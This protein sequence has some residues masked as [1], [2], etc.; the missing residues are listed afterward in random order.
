MDLADGEHACLGADGVQL[1]AG[2]VGAQ[3]G[4]QLVADVAL[5]PGLGWLDLGVR[6]FRFGV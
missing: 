5:H 4:Q 2:G 1:R 3:S 6:G